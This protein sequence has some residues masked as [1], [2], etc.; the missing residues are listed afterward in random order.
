MRGLE[1]ISIVDRSHERESRTLHQP[2]FGDPILLCRR[3]LYYYVELSCT[4]VFKDPVLLVTYYYC[5]E[6]DDKTI[7]V[8][9]TD[10]CEV[11]LRHGR[12]NLPHVYP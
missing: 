9:I 5:F 8:R 2:T 6:Q 12:R 1:K 11:V 10:T 3:F 7:C 4:T